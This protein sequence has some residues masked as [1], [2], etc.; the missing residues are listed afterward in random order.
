MGA[1]NYRKP[2]AAGF[3]FV[4]IFLYLFKTLP[5]QFLAENM[6]FASPVLQ[7]TSSTFVQADMFNG[8]CRLIRDL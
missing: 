7:K 6:L 5:G 1:Q 8:I 3:K 4:H 2:L